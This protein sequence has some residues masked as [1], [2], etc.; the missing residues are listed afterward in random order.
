VLADIAR[1]ISIVMAVLGA[2]GA[3]TGLDVGKLAP[4]IGKITDILG[5]LSGLTTPS[6]VDAA[7]ADLAAI[8]ST[9]NSDGVLTD[10]PIVEEAL[11]VIAKFKVVEADYMA[12][13]VALISSKFSFNGVAGSLIA[14]KDGGSAAQLLGM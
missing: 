13:Q 11:V 7:I 4:I 9:L 3:Q 5:S 6:T 10:V 2:V 1:I 12:G 8:L 14:L